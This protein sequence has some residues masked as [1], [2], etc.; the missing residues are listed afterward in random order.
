MKEFFLQQPRTIR[1]A[2][3]DAAGQA[4]QEK[5]RSWVEDPSELPLPPPTQHHSFR[6]VWQNFCSLGEPYIHRIWDAA[7]HEER[8]NM[9]L[10]ST[11][12]QQLRL[13]QWSRPLMP[14]PLRPPSSQP[15]KSPNSHPTL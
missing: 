5:L 15:S 9:F 13:I 6:A 2:L 8:H 4:K 10:S 3:Y 7:T 12:P 14:I 11:T 1:H